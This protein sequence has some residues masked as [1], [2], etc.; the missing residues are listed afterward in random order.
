MGNGDFDSVGDSI[1]SGSGMK[2]QGSCFASAVAAAVQ[3]HASQQL[4][5]GPLGSASD[6]G[7][8]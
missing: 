1:D 8:S 6:S 3:L 4:G 7:L 5:R 2:F